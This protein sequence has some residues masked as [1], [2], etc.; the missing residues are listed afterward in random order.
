M[1]VPENL[2]RRAGGPAH[3]RAAPDIAPGSWN[4][5]ALAEAAD[6]VGDETAVEHANDGQSGNDLVEGLVETRALFRFRQ[7]FPLQETAVQ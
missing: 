4:M 5:A 3:S 2:S 7:I 1:L 6:H